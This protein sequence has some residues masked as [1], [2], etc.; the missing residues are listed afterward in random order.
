MCTNLICA[1]GPRLILSYFDRPS[2]M[3][4][5]AILVVPVLR[6][7]VLHFV[8]LFFDKINYLSILA[9]TFLQ[10]YSPQGVH[11]C[12]NKNLDERKEK[13]EDQPDVDHLC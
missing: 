7:E 11:V 8:F 3:I 13:I 5:L 6:F 1:A 9:F 10:N 4:D 2:V 12:V